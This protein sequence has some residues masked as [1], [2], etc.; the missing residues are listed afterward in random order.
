MKGMGISNNKPEHKSYRA[1]GKQCNA[2]HRSIE[3][4]LVTK[5]RGDENDKPANERDAVNP[6]RMCA[7]FNIFKETFQ[8]SADIAFIIQS[9]TKTMR[10]KKQKQM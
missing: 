2:C 5:Q 4:Q 3:V 1:N 10:C 9:I 8:S 7:T 6:G